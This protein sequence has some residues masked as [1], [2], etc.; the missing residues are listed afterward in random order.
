MIEVYIYSFRDLWPLSEACLE[1]QRPLFVAWFILDHL[2]KELAG[3]AEQSTCSA[4]A[5]THLTLHVHLQ[6]HF[7]SL[8]HCT[9]FACAGAL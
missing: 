5:T 1:L 6:R 9:F 2:S 8:L 4:A 3:H 7:R